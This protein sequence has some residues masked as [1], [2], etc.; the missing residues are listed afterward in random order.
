MQHGGHPTK[1]RRPTCA[2]PNPQ[3]GGTFW[4]QPQDQ[5]EQTEGDHGEVRGTYIM[6][7]GVLVGVTSTGCGLVLCRMF[8]GAGAPLQRITH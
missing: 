7:R 2:K 8:R 6:T 1:D 3:P 4:E 5:A